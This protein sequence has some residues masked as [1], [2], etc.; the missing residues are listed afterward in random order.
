MAVID[1]TFKAI[2]FRVWYTYYAG[3]DFPIHSASTE[4]NDPEE[5]EIEDVELHPQ[6]D[7]PTE[8]EDAILE[9]TECEEFRTEAY[10]TMKRTVRHG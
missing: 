2:D 9:L 4:P 1:V 6:Y 7:L 8:I 10:R 5:F 3:T